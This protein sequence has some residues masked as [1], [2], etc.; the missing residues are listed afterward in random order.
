MMCSQIARLHVRAVGWG[1]W[2]CAE[3]QTNRRAGQS[4]SRRLVAYQKRMEK[5]ATQS[6][7]NFGLLPFR[8]SAS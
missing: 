1:T 3:G 6:K 7:N 2:D 4:S 8:K 5:L